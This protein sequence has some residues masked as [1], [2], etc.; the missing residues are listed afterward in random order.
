MDRES[1][2]PGSD[3]DNDLELFQEP[4]IEDADEQDDESNPSLERESSVLVSEI[5]KEAERNGL[6]I[7][8]EEMS[9]APDIEPKAEQA[10]AAEP[11]AKRDEQAAAPDSGPKAD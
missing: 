11:S 8:M 10:D 9:A 2:S 4:E 3:A 1:G 7:G 5:L 6:G